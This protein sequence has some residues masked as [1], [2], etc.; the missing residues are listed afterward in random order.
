MIEPF[1]IKV[2]DEVLE[3][4]R[5]R[6]RRA[7]FPPPIEGAGWSQGIDLSWLRE[8][9]AHWAERYDW[10]A[11][12]AEMNRWPHFRSQIDGLSIHFLHAQSARKDAMP[13]LLTH[14]WP[15]S[16]LELMR[17]LPL[18]VDAGF[19]VVAPSLP[20][21]GFSSA[22]TQSGLNNFG[23]A[24]AFAE[25]MS[26]LGYQ[27]YGA[28]GGD[29]GA[30]VCT[31]LALLHP[32]R[33]LGLHLN[34]IPGS[35]LPDP[36]GPPHTPEERA[37]LEEEARWYADEGGYMHEQ[38][39]CPATVGA[40]L[41]DSPVGLLAWIAEKLRGWSEC[42]GDLSRRFTLDEVLTHVTLYWV[43]RTATS[44]MRLYYENRLRPL[45]LG[46]GERV[47]VP[48]AVARF[49]AEAPFPPRSWIER[50]FDLR[51]YTALPRG[52]H[53][54]AWEEPRLLADDVRAFFCGDRD[55]APII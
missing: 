7:R 41:E 20:G 22:P 30:S 54:A 29:I 12:E 9:A 17:V 42:G 49:P 51:R 11:A 6:L 37:F 21:Y 53:F 44:S 24:S 2:A 32:S 35:Y 40:A 46:P 26:R 55:Q 33:L 50:G 47:R 4:L 10:R 14:G 48:T 39:T 15:G 13:L 27:H 36:G 3:D 34:Y 28:Q 43:T 23:I 52:G 18:L 1:R 45:H 8:A 5:A 25:L 19:H 16:F 31:C 38:R